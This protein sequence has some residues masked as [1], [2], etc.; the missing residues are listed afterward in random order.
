MRLLCQRPHGAK[1]DDRSNCV[2][3][4]AAWRAARI[5]AGR[6]RGVVGSR[7]T[8]RT[9]APN[10]DLT[11]SAFCGSVAVAG[12]MCHT[13]NCTGN[14]IV[15]LHQHRYG[16]TSREALAQLATAFLTSWCCRYR[17]DSRQPTWRLPDGPGQGSRGFR[18]TFFRR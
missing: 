2:A 7:N 6:L 1:L 15:M 11:L 12:T 10:V 5:V 8:L 16:Q 9:C 17:S 4:H 18:Q 3:A 13:E 14:A